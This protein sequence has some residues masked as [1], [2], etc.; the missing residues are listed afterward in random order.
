[1]RIRQLTT[2]AAAAALLFASVA[3][4]SKAD[5]DTP[6]GGGKD[7]NGITVV[8]D[9]T[10]HVSDTAVAPGV[11][12]K[13]PD[14]FRGKIIASWAKD[15]QFG[16]MEAL[17]VLHAGGDGEDALGT[18][19]FALTHDDVNDRTGPAYATLDLDGRIIDGLPR[20]LYSRSGN[21]TVDSFVLEN[22]KLQQLV[23][24]FDGEF[25]ERSVPPSTDEPDASDTPYYRV[26]GAVRYI[27]P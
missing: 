15:G 20:T 9:G 12:M 14:M 18:G 5:D 16:S 2:F 7:G 22:N 26:S 21:V 23:Y 19:T 1:M 25:S 11:T 17:L 27:A 4:S 8:Y 6:G 3:C 10:E 13:F 24:R